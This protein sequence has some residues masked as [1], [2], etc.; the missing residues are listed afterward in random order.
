MKLVD[1]TL[2]NEKGKWS[3]KSL[4]VFVS[5]S[6]A[7]IYA[8]ASFILPIFD[9][10]FEF[11]ETLFLGFLSISTAGLGMSIVDKRT[12][13]KNGKDFDTEINVKHEPTNAKN[14][15]GWEGKN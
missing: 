6:F 14:F 1:D 9:I 3:R 4:T 12:A 2:K 13:V 10:P 11:I 7:V 8:L 5:F 15:D